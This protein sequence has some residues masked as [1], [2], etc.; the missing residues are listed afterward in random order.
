MQGPSPPLPSKNQDRPRT[1][2]YEK[3]ALPAHRC[4]LCFD[5][6]GL[7]EAHLCPEKL[8]HRDDPLE[9]TKAD[10]S[11]K[12]RRALLARAPSLRWA[13]VSLYWTGLPKEICRKIVFGTDLHRFYFHDEVRPLARERLEMLGKFT[14]ISELR[15]LNECLVFHTRML[16]LQ[17][18]KLIPLCDHFLKHFH[19]T[20]EGDWCCHVGFW[21]RGRRRATGDAISP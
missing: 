17:T 12:T 4:R 16:R 18:G 9:L 11:P 8:W 7:D 20:E 21:T 10:P 15:R 19:L 6:V 3:L 1:G 13:L 2:Q 5:Q 14:Q